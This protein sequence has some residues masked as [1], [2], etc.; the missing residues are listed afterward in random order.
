MPTDEIVVDEEGK[1]NGDKQ[2][3]QGRNVECFCQPDVATHQ[4]PRQDGEYQLFEWYCGLVVSFV[5]VVFLQL[6]ERSRSAC[7]VR[8]VNIV[9][10]E[11]R[12]QR[13][14]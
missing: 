2:I 14:L 3:L 12:S 9:Y 6:D 10:E 13:T 7:R 8:T 5:V 11:G 4:Q 1:Q